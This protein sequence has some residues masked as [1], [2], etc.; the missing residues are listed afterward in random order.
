MDLVAKRTAAKDAPKGYWRWNIR[1]P[2]AYARSLARQ[3]KQHEGVALTPS[4]LR[5][6]VRED[7]HQS[8]SVADCRAIM[9][10][11]KLPG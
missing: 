5:A 9:R 2:Y 3:V 4:R 10:K 7:S 1:D 11:A 6:A 8:I